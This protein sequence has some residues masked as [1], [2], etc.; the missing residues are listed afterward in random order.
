[1][2]SLRRKIVALLLAVTMLSIYLPAS[3]TMACTPVETG[4]KVELPLITEQNTNVGSVVVE[5]KGT[6]EL[7]ATYK[8]NEQAISDGW[9]IYEAQ[10]SVGGSKYDLLYN[11]SLYRK[12]FKGGKQTFNMKVNISNYR[13]NTLF[14]SAYASIKKSTSITTAAPYGASKVY[15]YKQGLKSDGSTVDVYRSDPNNA[16]QYETGMSVSNFYSLGFDVSRDSGWIVVEFDKPIING[17]GNDLDILEDTWTSPYV[18]EA[19][20]VYVSNN[21]RC[22]KYV[23]RANNTNKINETNS[24][25]KF[26]LSAAGMCS[27]KYVKLQDVSN[28]DEVNDGFDLNAVL[29]LHDYIST[30]T[31]QKNA[32][33]SGTKFCPNGSG[34]MYFTFQINNAVGYHNYNIFQLLCFWLGF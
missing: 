30:R 29:A 13:V 3:K 12:S 16:L 22:W 34:G 11:N 26:D 25:S 9:L 15:A 23:G 27:A 5:K 8:L 33:A 24:S 17:E 1:M 10:L 4:E 2:K 14:L 32:W 19:A 7:L 6:K 31:E 18:V 20:D 28:N 21:G